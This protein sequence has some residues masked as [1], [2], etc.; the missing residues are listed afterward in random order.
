[1]GIDGKAE[2][3]QKVDEALKQS[4]DIQKTAQQFAAEI[5][6]GMVRINRATVGVDN[7]PGTFEYYTS[8]LGH[9]MWLWAALVP[10][11]A[12]GAAA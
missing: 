12:Q 10:A 4:K 5:Q 7:S 11:A 8:Q 3:A 9:G 6:A 1:M 2:L